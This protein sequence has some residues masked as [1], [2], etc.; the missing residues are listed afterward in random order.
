MPEPV[1]LVLVLDVLDDFEVLRA[2]PFM[3]AV[4]MTKALAMAMLVVALRLELFTRDVGCANEEGKGFAD[5]AMG[6]ALE[7][8]FLLDDLVDGLLAL[9]AAEDLVCE[10]LAGFGLSAHKRANKV[11][12]THDAADGRPC[13]R[14]GTQSCRR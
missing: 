1:L 5:G 2:G 10:S 14:R 9:E 13:H 7:G 8:A 3:V 12:H 6:A 4:T 11:M